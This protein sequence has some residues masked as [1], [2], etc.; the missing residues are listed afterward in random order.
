MSFHVD[1][2]TGPGPTLAPVPASERI[3]VLDVVRGIALL[4]IFVMNIEFFNRP[5]AELELGMPTTA[6]AADWWVGWFVQVFVR[7]K[8]WTLFAL[9]FGM[10]FALMQMRAE[11]AGRNFAIP[12]LRRT[13]VLA[14]FGLL[15]HL[16]LWGGDI[17]LSYAMGALV[18]LLVFLVRPDA[19]IAVAVATALAAVVL[20]RPEL[21]GVMA[22]SLL[23]AALALVMRHWP[24]SGPRLAG[25]A[26]YLLP[27]LLMMMSGAILSMQPPTPAAVASAPAVGGGHGS[28]ESAV[29]AESLAREQ[30]RAQLAAQERQVMSSGSYREAV[31]FRMRTLPGQFARDLPVVVIVVGMFLVG[32][33]LI[34]SG[35]MANP[36]AHLALFRTLAW[37]G[38]PAGL[39]LSVAAATVTVSYVPGGTDGPSQFAMGLAMLGALPACMGYLGAIVLGFHRVTLRPALGV[40]APAGRM[41]LTHYLAQSLIAALVFY[42]HGLGLWGMSRPRQLLVVLAVFALQ[43]VFSH[44]WLRRFRFGPVEWLWRSLTYLEVPRL[45]RDASAAS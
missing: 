3:E 27:A 45:R 44:W 43:V 1:Q 26:L 34:R 24:L 29:H 4:G 37:V 5:L 8:F 36:T 10:G 25:L 14:A 28:P 30:S 42:G 15:H 23:V 17:L 22:A 13:L 2:H 16:L 40:F 18:L 11:R 38:L 41:A 39:G 12:Y 7:G 32:T 9:L 31:A 6:Q 21:H 20:G 35:A 19:L 33:W